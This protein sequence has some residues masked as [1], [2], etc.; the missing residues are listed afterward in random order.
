VRAS[1]PRARA[2]EEG[3]RVADFD[4]DIS[5]SDYLGGKFFF[6]VGFFN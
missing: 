2:S 6:V 3:A 1:H 4:T 5:V